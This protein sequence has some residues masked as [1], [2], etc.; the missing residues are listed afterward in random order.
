MFGEIIKKKNGAEFHEKNT[1]LTV[2]DGGG[3]IALWAFAAA[4][5]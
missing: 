4:S 5:G 3:L 2:N 1:S